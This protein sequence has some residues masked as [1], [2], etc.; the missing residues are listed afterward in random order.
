MATA[1]EK[2][3]TRLRKLVED[4]LDARLGEI[5]CS[6]EALGSRD[7]VAA[8]AHAIMA[9]G[10]RVRPILTLL[11]AKACGATEAQMKDALSAACAIELLH[12]YTLVHDD[13]PCMD[14]DTERRGKPTVWAKYGEGTAVLVGDYLQAM[15]FGQIAQCRRA[16]A[17]L[18]VLNRAAQNVI[19]GQITD[20]AAAKVPS[21]TWTYDLI[22]FTYQNKTAELISTA[23][24]LGAIAAGAKKSVQTAL[25]L[26]G[27]SVGL[28]FQYIDDLLDAEQ[29]KEGNELSAITALEGTEKVHFY[30]EVFND[31]AL[32]ALKAVPGD[33]KILKRFAED[34]LKRIQ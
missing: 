6:D 9:G 32:E 3:I 5:G 7:F 4:A 15:A 23:C 19:H 26:Y 16:K 31:L 30:A 27:N 33:T 22:D 17:M 13:L 1:Y 12:N 18:P 11:S 34:L 29:A 10:K 21:S 8:A 2:E 20:I 25:A 28:S 14:N 24:E